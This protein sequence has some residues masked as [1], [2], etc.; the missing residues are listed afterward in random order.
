MTFIAQGNGTQPVIAT[1]AGDIR[2]AARNVC[3]YDADPTVCSL[4]A[5]PPAAIPAD[6]DTIPPG[7]PHHGAPDRWPLREPQ[8][9]HRHHRRRPLRRQGR[10]RVALALRV[11]TQCRF[12]TRTGS[13]TARALLHE[14]P[15]P[16]RRHV[17]SELEPAPRP[18]G[19]WCPGTWR[20]WSRA[21]DGA[22]NLES[23]ALARV[24][25]GQFTIARPRPVGLVRR[26][27]AALLAAGLASALA[28]PLAGAA[29]ADRAA[30]ERGAAWLAR[31]ATGAPGGQ[32]ADTIVALR[33]AGR[34]RAALA[35]RL[36]ALARVAPG[37]AV[38]A[39]GAAKVALAAVAGGRDPRRLGGVD[40]L[41]RITNRYAAGRYGE[42]AFDQ[43]LSMLALSA[44]GAVVP[45]TAIRATLAARAGGGWGLHDVAH[46][47]RLG[48]RHLL[49]DRGPARGRRPGLASRAAGRRHLDP[50]PAQP[51]GGLASDGGGRP[52]DANSTASAIRALRS[53]GRT[54]PPG[55]RAALRA[56]QQPDGGFRSTRAA[57]GSRLLA[58]ND[59]VPALMGATLPVR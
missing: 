44:A 22:G 28:A 47:A 36:D 48:G 59:A 43:G 21:T 37:Y 6:A 33:S 17:R 20:V 26:C 54:P 31:N 34:S 23:V 9:D 29:T 16:A 50:R 58:T 15:V 42:N 49:G 10:R 46:G 56:L 35:P 3:S 14:A 7:Q 24:N 32:Q 53:L 30:A 4:P 8:G 25:G 55:T 40:Y 45:P 57:A 19:P 41:R 27:A 13:L 2:S 5:A 51:G 1:R 11:G 12:R 52:A 38:T 18:S 39:G